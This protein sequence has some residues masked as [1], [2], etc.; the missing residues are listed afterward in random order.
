MRA[1]AITLIGVVIVTSCS[2]P[3]NSPEPADKDQSGSDAGATDGGATNG[4]ATDA[5]ATDAAATDAGG[6]EAG[7]TDAGETEGNAIAVTAHR[8]ATGTGS[9]IISAGVPLRQGQLQPGGLSGV[10]LWRNGTEVAASISALEG[11]YADGSVI[12]L[13]VQYDAGT[14]AKGTPVTGYELRLS[15]STVARAAQTASAIKDVPDGIWALLPAHF[16]GV[17]AAVWGPLVPLSEATGSWAAVDAD[18]VSAANRRW[19]QC[20][21]QVTGTE[22]DLSPN[23]EHFSSKYDQPKNRIMYWARGGDIKNLER[24]LRQVAV[25]RNYQQTW[26]QWNNQDVLSMAMAYWWTG[27][28]SYRTTALKVAQGA[29]MNEW[30]GPP[31]NPGYDEGRITAR[32]M[33]WAMQAWLLGYGSSMLGN[34]TALQWLDGLAQ[35]QVTTQQSNGAWYEYSRDEGGYGANDLGYPANTQSNFMAALRAYY[36]S[37]YTE[38]RG[39]AQVAG[40]TNAIRRNA[41]FLTTQYDATNRTWHYWSTW[42]QGDAQV[43]LSDMRNLALMH[44]MA[45][46]RAYHD[47]SGSSYLTQADQALAAFAANVPNTVQTEVCGQTYSLKIFTEGYY[48][49]QHTMAMAM[50]L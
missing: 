6:T 5:A 36:L 29:G 47:G 49:Y 39:P 26:R 33:G 30:M 2:D 4:G 44:T 48:L 9:T 10:G 8:L 20:S 27:V 22:S 7:P 46:Y 37:L 40:V 15:G 21:E 28:P 35:R 34:F 24:G 12:S 11:R 23:V 25:S 45:Y 17:V 3:A 41:D 42:A 32:N 43:G 31:S 18:W 38:Y 16:K 13:L 14:M 50:G 19:E 1:I